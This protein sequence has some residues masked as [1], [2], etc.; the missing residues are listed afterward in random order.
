[1]RA[2]VFAN[3]SLNDPAAALQAAATGDLIIAADGGALHC[4]RLGLTPHVIIGDMDSLPPEVIQAMEAAGSE[5]VRFP[6]RKDFTD[7]EL[8]LHLAL[9]RGADE[10]LV[11]AGAGGRWDQTLANMLLPA[12]ASLAPLRISLVDGLQ[13]I[14]LLRGGGTLRLRGQP[15]DTVSLIPLGGDGRGITT[16]GL[17]YPL[18]DGLLSFGSTRGISNVMLSDEAEVHL[19]EGILVCVVLH[20][21]EG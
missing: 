1:M 3:G 17:E 18:D 16:H 10:A 9:E 8:A 2:I 6:A 13:E 4:R 7:L 15:G 19:K 14:L 5:I 20:Q 21:R 12:E 11:L